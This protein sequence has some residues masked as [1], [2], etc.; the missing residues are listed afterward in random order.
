MGREKL[1]CS[2]RV[3]LTT[4]GLSVTGALP[5][6]PR[7]GAIACA[8]DES[9]PNIR[10]DGAIAAVASIECNVFTDLASPVLLTSHFGMAASNEPLTS[11][12]TSAQLTEK[13]HP[14]TDPM[15]FSAIHLAR[16]ILA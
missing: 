16:C 12:V 10:M 9:V 3:P 5:G 1:D 11:M 2:T 7:R 8:N 15:L 13:L 4:T 14:D 6:K